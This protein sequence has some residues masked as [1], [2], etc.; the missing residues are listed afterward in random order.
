MKKRYALVTRS[1]G[2]PQCDGLIGGPV[3]SNDDF[4]NQ[5]LIFQITNEPRNAFFEDIF[6]IVNRYKNT[7]P[8]Q[9]INSLKR[10]ICPSQERRFPFLN[11]AITYPGRK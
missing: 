9:V 8:I 7:D 1:N 11:L 2:L 6:F 10:R 5:I 3:T 4:E